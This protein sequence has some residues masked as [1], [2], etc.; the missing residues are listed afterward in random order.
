MLD[1]LL[2]GPEKDTT[3]ALSQLREVTEP[4]ICS[5]GDTKGL[6]LIELIRKQC[7][8]YFPI[9]TSERRATRQA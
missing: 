8:Q 2:R 7:R 9:R 6:A 5:V 3:Q 4:N 1:G